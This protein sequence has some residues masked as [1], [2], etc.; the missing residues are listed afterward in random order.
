TTVAH[1][2]ALLP[3]PSFRSRSVPPAHPPPPPFFFPAPSPTLLY[4]LSLHDALPISWSSGTRSAA[5][6]PPRCPPPGRS[7]P[8]PP[9]PPRAGRPSARAT[10][11]P[12]RGATRTP[13]C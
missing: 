4:T 11:P 8:G 2:A 3:H 6:P 5:A 12:V 13:R 9:S 10:I 7:R 1:P